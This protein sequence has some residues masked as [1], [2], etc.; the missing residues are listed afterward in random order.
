M[1]ARKLMVEKIFDY[2]SVYNGGGFADFIQKDDGKEELYYGP[3][4]WTEA[5]ENIY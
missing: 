1:S 2:Y 4:W 5:T 3:A